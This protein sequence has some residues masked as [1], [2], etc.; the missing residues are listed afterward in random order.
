MDGY[1]ATTP[2]MKAYK[3]AFRTESG[4][5]DGWYQV[6]VPAPADGDKIVITLTGSFAAGSKIGMDDLTVQ[7]ASTI[8]FLQFS[9]GN[10]TAAG[11]CLV[12]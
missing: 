7:F 1:Y 6:S 2:L 9:C 5:D 8:G 11:E 10:A 3:Q 12:P 4:F